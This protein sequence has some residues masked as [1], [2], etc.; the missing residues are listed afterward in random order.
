VATNGNVATGLVLDDISFSLT[1]G[2][3]LGLLGRTGS[4]KTTLTRL[5]FRFYDPAQGTIRLDDRPLPELS[6]AALRRSVGL[7]TQEIQLFHAS[8]RDNLTLFDPTVPD[9][10]ILQTLQTLGLWDWYQTLPH[11]LDTKLAPGGSGLSA[12]QAQLLAFVRVFLKNPGL[13]ILDEAS[14]RLDPATERLLEQAVNRLLE[15]RTAIIIAHRL[16]TVQ[17][18]DQIMILQNGQCLE[19]GRREELA[20]DIDSHFAG[21]LQTG[22]EEALA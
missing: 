19:Y 6:V 11:G 14:S 10:L 20:R 18:V 7:V 5:L 17:R 1:P 21:L 13:V 2:M 16:A 3:K 4:G 12:G 9:E 15:G 8:V 22:L